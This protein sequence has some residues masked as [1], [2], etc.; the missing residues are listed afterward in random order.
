MLAGAEKQLQAELKDQVKEEMTA[1]ETLLAGLFDYAGLY[2]PASLDLRTASRNYREYRRS[3]RACALGRFI[4]NLDRLDEV[5]SIAG[6]SLG[7]FSLSVIA[8][9]N[10]DWAVLCK[11]VDSGL[12]IE[13]VEIKCGDPSAS[14]RIVQQVPRNLVAYFEV[15]IYASS[16][17]ALETIKGAGARAKIRLGGVIPEAIP[18]IPDVAQ[19]LKTLADLRLPFKATAGLHHPLRSMRALTYHPQSPTGVMHGF[20]NL[21]T[22]SAL[23]FFGGDQEEAIQVLAE[24]NPAAWQI[25]AESI[26]WR[27]H[28]W[29]AEQFETLRRDFFIGIG[30]CSFEEP[31]HDLE[32][33]GWH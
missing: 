30:S 14:E 25:C 24:E 3:P 16:L 23:L 7:E 6:E 5:R 13:S 28:T 20:M 12:H 1:I 11:H 9:E 17:S 32:S 27:N 8:A 19:M 21:S 15:P 29:T 31:I 22:A 2:P 10:A 4:V 18:S 26:S 33:L